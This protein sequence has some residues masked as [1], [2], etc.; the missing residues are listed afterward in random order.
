MTQLCVPIFVE[1][2][3][4]AKR[5]VA[6]AIEAGADIVELRLDLVANYADV[7]VIRAGL[8]VPMILTCRSVAEG[9]DDERSDEE[10]IAFLEKASASGTPYVDVE[11]QMYQRVPAIE[12]DIPRQLI[13]S[14]HDFK[15]RPSRLYS[16][17]DEM[18]R[19]RA[20]V[21]KIAWQARSIRD[22]I[23]AFELLQSRQ[24]STIALCMGEAGLMS[25]VLAKKF[26]AFLT[27]ASLRPTEATAPGQP[28]IEEIKCL[29]R[30]DAINEK[31]K[32]FGVVGSPI[33][34]SMSPAIHNAAFDSTGFDGVY[35]PMLVEPS[36]E[37]FKAFMESFLAFPSLDLAGLSITI[38]HKENALRYLQSKG[39]AID[40]LAQKIGAVNTIVIT[41]A[42][43]VGAQL[44]GFNTD[45][46]AI[47]D[48]ITDKLNISRDQLSDYRVAII[49]AGGTARTAV[50][51]LAEYGATVVIYN[52]TR[53]KS[54]ALANEFNNRSGRVV[55]ARM[56]K[57]CDSCCHIFINATPVGMSPNVDASPLDGQTVHFTPDTLVFDTIYNPAETKLLR[58]AREQ[59]AKTIGGSEMF[60]RQAAEQFRIWT[61]V[62]APVQVMRQ[63]LQTR[64]AQLAGSTSE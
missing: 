47:L 42:V 8:S 38:P 17:I 57:L 46:N 63:A 34:H 32:V 51:A 44:R 22:N 33:G 7:N 31:T 25:R 64:L 36:Y 60:I 61:G 43:S 18:N 20:S 49:G 2:I 27:F 14:V 3:E 9:G 21:N 54:D 6:A 52:R 11:L 1:G 53:D 59:G 30:W 5:N 39:A 37:S 29:Y 26:G 4:Q 23:D 28:T 55:A 10:R 48:C 50:A 16:L 19:S 40:P 15:G 24:K 58:Q 41:P 62:D 12:A 13:I 45:Y 35:L 56:E